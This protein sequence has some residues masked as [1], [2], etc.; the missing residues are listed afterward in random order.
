MPFDFQ[1]TRT[2]EACLGHRAVPSTLTLIPPMQTFE[3]I[4]AMLV[5]HLL[6]K[7]GDRHDFLDKDGLAIKSGVGHGAGSLK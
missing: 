7:E 4:A 5:I 1:P 3:G 2:V 6:V